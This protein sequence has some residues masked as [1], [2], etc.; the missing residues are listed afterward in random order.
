MNPTSIFPVYFTGFADEVAPDIDVQI[1][2]TR[3]LSW[4]AI[5]LRK[6]GVPGFPVGN[7]HDIPDEAFDRVVAALDDAGVRVNSLGSTLGNGAQDIRNPFDDELAAARRGATRAQRLGASFVRVMSYPVGDV[8]DLRETER[9]RRLREIVRIFSDV[10]VTVVHENC[11]NYG[12]MSWRHTLSLLENVPGLKLVFDTGNCVKDA[13]HAR[14][15]PHP[16]QLSL[17]FFRQ[18]REHVVYVHIK[19][20]VFD[21]ETGHVRWCFLGEGQGDVHRVVADLLAGGYR[22]GLSIEPHMGGSS[23]YGPPTVENR[24]RIYLEYGRR[25]EALVA[26]LAG[27]KKNEGTAV[28][29]GGEPQ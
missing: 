11:A 23:F 14:P 5:E 28:P 18:V 8:S 1:E 3:E 21:A 10:G 24:R 17:E 2:V 27:A 13:D 19:D 25:V 15:A 4:R 7:L 12:G 6:V 26:S 29:V 9:F 16:R 20:G 22:G